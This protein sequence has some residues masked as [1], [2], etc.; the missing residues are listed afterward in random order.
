[1][2]DSP[3]S[4]GDRGKQLFESSD[5]DP[6]ARRIDRDQSASRS[7][8]RGVRF[9]DEAEFD[10]GNIHSAYDRRIRGESLEAARVRAP[11]RGVL[12]ASINF[13]SETGYRLPSRSNSPATKLDNL[14]ALRKELKHQESGP[15]FEEE[16]SAQK[17][18]SRE[19]SRSRSG[20]PERRYHTGV[21]RDAPLYQRIEQ[22]ELEN[23]PF[24]IQ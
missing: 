17:P 19:Q 13:G 21:S 11:E 14:R 9:H 3:Q 18:Q 7:R 8:S 16:V 15:Q 10:R 1:M 12:A 2:D 6:L 20:N 4:P 22:A 23:D 5:S 24:E